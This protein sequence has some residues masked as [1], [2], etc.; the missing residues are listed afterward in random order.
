MASPTHVTSGRANF[1]RLMDRHA[2]GMHEPRPGPPS[3]T[4]AADY[5]NPGYSAV[6]STG[7]PARA[8][9]AGVAHGYEARDGAR[10]M[11]VTGSAPG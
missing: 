1:A 10:G 3:E 2:A 5:F 8:L 6:G 9:G 7:V 11:C 4:V